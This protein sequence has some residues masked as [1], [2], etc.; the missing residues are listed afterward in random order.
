[1]W[2][3]VFPW[4]LTL[5]WVVIWF[6]SCCWSW[7]T[8]DWLK[9]LAFQLWLIKAWLASQ[10]VSH[11]RCFAGSWTIKWLSVVFA[12]CGSICMVDLETN[13]CL[14]ENLFWCFHCF[15][16][17]ICLDIRLVALYAALFVPLEKGG[18][19]GI[20]RDMKSLNRFVSYLISFMFVH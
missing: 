8:I 14:C 17:T 13:F 9:L 6:C 20:F 2:L 4:F 10:H 18:F 12:L 19:Q 1:M 16:I 7:R 11:H 15:V 5:L 3:W